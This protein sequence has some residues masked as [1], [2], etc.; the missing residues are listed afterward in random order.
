MAKLKNQADWLSIHHPDASGSLLEGLEETFTI[1]R[2]DISPTLRRCLATTNIIEIPKSGGRRR[3]GR[4]S[5]WRDGKMVL[6]WAASAF[7]ATE[8]NFRRILGY[9][10]IWMLKAA[11]ENQR[12]DDKD[13]AA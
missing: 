3:T 8:E 4:V 10:D 12:G 7:A 5:R 1:N 13:R 9:R 11:L 2:L 6:R